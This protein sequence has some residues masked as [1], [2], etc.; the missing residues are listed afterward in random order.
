MTPDPGAFDL[1]L[2][3][4]RRGFDDLASQFS[5]LRATAGSLLGFTGVA[6]SILVGAPGKPLGPWA[7]LLLGLAAATSSGVVLAAALVLKP[8]KII[9][10]PDVDQLV[11]WA[12]QGDTRDAMARNLALTYERAYRDN[13]RK[14]VIVTRIHMGALA[15][16]AITVLLLV[17]RM[18]GV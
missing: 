15:A 8:V 2:T 3:E 4:A 5:K 14:L 18:T 1:A 10:G 17:L 12:D 7:E 6:F 11:R 9:P 16:F 13:R